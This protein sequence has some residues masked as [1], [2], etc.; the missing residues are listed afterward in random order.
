MTTKFKSKHDG[1][2]I[3][4]MQH[5]GTQPTAVGITVWAGS[6]GH[7]INMR[8]RG[9]DNSDWV[10]VIPEFDD[11]DVVATDWV[12]FG[13]DGFWSAKDADLNKGYERVDG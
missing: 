11:G 2:E 8:Y 3:E 5:D 6:H 10:L 9:G 12:G 13:S 4:A 1:H 7:T